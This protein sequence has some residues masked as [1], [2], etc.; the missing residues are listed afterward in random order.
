MISYG[1]GT[2]STNHPTNLLALRVDLRTPQFD[3]CAFVLV[4]KS[5][6]VVIHF[7]RISGSNPYAAKYHNHVIS[8]TYLAPEFVYAR[9]AWSIIQMVKWKDTKAGGSVPK[10]G[11]G[12]EASGQDD[13]DRES[14]RSGGSNEGG[15]WSQQKNSF[16]ASSKRRKLDK[17]DEGRRERTGAID[18][19]AFVRM[20]FPFFCEAKS[21]SADILV[22]DYILTVKPGGQAGPHLYSQMGWYPGV[23]DVEEM[24]RQ[25]ISGHPNI[26]ETSGSN[27]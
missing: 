25:G 17:S 15:R 9:F 8:T 22:T 19:E 6:Q 14:N 10:R 1:H 16:R 5:G 24:K 4:P 20:Q 3:R 23:E 13:E 7:I 26:H 11:R 18:Q 21:A 27:E 2:I 12:G